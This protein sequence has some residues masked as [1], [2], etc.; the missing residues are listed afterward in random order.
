MSVTFFNMRRRAETDEAKKASE[1][2]KQH[3]EAETPQPVEQV[4]QEKQPKAKA[5]PKKA[6]AKK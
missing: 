6:A 4:P 2:V 1:S 3:K 5:K